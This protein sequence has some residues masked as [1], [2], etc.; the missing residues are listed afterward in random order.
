MNN[1]QLISL[2]KKY[3]YSLLETLLFG[4]DIDKPP[5]KEHSLAYL[6]FKWYEGQYLY[7]RLSNSDYQEEKTWG[8]RYW[9]KHAI[10]ESLPKLQNYL[11][12][13]GKMIYDKAKPT[14]LQWAEEH[15]ARDLERM[16]DLRVEDI[17]EASDYS[18]LTVPWQLEHLWGEIDFLLASNNFQPFEYL[19]NGKEV[20]MKKIRQFLDS[21]LNIKEFI[22]ERLTE[23]ISFLKNKQKE[24]KLNENKEWLQQKIR[25]INLLK[26]L[27]EAPL[28]NTSVWS[29]RNISQLMLILRSTVDFKKVS[30]NI[31]NTKCLKT[32]VWLMDLFY[33]M[34][35][36][37]NKGVEIPVWIEKAEKIYKMFEKP[38]P[39]SFSELT[40]LIEK[41]I[42]FTHN[43]G[44][45]LQDHLPPQDATLSPV[46]QEEIYKKT[47]EKMQYLMH[48]IWY[49]A[50]NK[51][52][53]EDFEDFLKQYGVFWQKSQNINKKKILY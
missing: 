51:Y 37:R 33:L 12:Q 48:V 38:F 3:Y 34:N 43:N 1:K 50:D 2:Y 52:K 7:L 45:L 39:S 16:M 21:C 31:K 11:T 41:I 30:D 26:Q 4:I 18:S 9:I 13:I 25:G 20:I 40:M 6:V 36:F 29:R 28:T 10:Q 15:D 32:V 49:F 44:N 47:G 24:G 19:P 23:V 17:I 5:S 35:Y 42:S 22:E 46:E 8:E 27:A 53:N 14:F